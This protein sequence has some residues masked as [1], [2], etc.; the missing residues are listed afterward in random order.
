MK[1]VDRLARG[2]YR[3]VGIGKRFDALV[4]QWPDACLN[5]TVGLLI[6]LPDVHDPEDLRVLIEASR[7]DDQTVNR[8]VTYLFLGP[9]VVSSRPFLYGNS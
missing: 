3:V 7:V 9:V 2:R 8:V 1:L 4:S 6:R 5:E